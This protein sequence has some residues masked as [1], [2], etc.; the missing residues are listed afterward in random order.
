MEIQ[1]NFYENFVYC[2]QALRHSIFFDSFN[3]P[4]ARLNRRLKVF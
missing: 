4:A 2:F 1:T 3:R